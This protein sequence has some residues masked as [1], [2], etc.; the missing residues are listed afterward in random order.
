MSRKGRY[1]YISDSSESDHQPRRRKYKP[2]EEISREFKKIK[3]PMFNGKV[4]KGE[5][6]KAWLSG[7][8]KYFHIYKY[9][10]RLKARIAIY[11]LTEKADIW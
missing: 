3:P 1:K 9:S 11:N 10:D 6:A 7:M 4:D 5:E 2:Y 8:N